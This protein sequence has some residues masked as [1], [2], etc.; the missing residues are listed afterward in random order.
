LFDSYQWAYAEFWVSHDADLNTVEKLAPASPLKSAYFAGY[1]EPRFWIMELAK[2]GIRCWVAAWANSASNAWML[3]H[4][5][6]TELVRGFR[7]QG[8]KTHDFRLK[9]EGLPVT[10]NATPGAPPSG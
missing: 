5:M 8:I 4:D 9:A 3:G 2:E 1:E 6:R 7:A 10:A